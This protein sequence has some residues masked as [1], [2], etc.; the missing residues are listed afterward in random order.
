MGL[1]L[2]LYRFLLG[3]AVGGEEAG[4]DKGLNK[5][6][7]LRCIGDIREWHNAAD[8]AFFFIAADSDQ[9]IHNRGKDNFAGIDL[10]KGF[11]G[12]FGKGAPDATELHTVL[13][14]RREIFIRLK[15]QDVILA[16]RPEEFQQKIFK[17]RQQLRVL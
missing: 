12:P 4:L 10:T 1:C 11:F 9:R 13:R 7:F 14:V 8:S 16:A 2:R 17:K 3:F 15:G 5:C 6:F